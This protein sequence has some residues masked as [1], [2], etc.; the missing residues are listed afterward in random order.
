MSNTLLPVLLYLNN[1]KCIVVGGGNVA[2]QKISQLLESN[3]K[4]TIISKICN[5]EL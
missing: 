3:A 1:Q 2:F 5:P 4:I